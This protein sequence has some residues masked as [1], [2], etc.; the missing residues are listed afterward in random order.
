MEERERAP[1]EV[2][3]GKVSEGVLY[4][5]KRTEMLEAYVIKGSFLPYENGFLLLWDGGDLIWRPLMPGE[6]FHTVRSLNE[7]VPVVMVPLDRLLADERVSASVKAMM[8]AAEEAFEME[9]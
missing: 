2:Y 9:G 3:Q 1:L 7:A 4:I 6:H 8:Q 5:E